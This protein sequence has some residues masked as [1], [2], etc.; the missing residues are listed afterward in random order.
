MAEELGD[1]LGVGF[2]VDVGRIVGDGGADGLGAADED[3]GGGGGGAEL[4]GARVGLGFLVGVAFF[5]G[6][7]LLVGDGGGV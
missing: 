2:G 6:D 1:P 3:V 5:V 7:G 4:L